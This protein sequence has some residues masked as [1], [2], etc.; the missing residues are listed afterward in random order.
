A[1]GLAGEVDGDRAS[2]LAAGDLG[3]AEAGHALHGVAH[4][5]GA[6]LRPAL[7]P[8]I[9]RRER[10]VDDLE[11]LGHLLRAGR[12]AAVVL[13]HAED[14]VTLVATPLHPALDLARPPAGHSDLRHD[15]PQRAPGAG[16]GGHPRIGPAVL[17]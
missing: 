11:H 1:R 4:G 2:D 10:A 15:Q 14:V 6:E 12:D 16:D 8:E 17:R 9:V 7:A 3:G 13:A 5:V